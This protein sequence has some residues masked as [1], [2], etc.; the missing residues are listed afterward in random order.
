MY[1]GEASAKYY[2]G[3][4]TDG[5][6]PFFY[7]AIQFQNIC[8]LHPSKS[9]NSTLHKVWKMCWIPENFYGPESL[10]KNF[11]MMNANFSSPKRLN[12]RAASQSRAQ[13]IPTGEININVVQFWAVQEWRQ[14][15]ISRARTPFPPPP[16]HLS[17]TCPKWSHTLG[18]KPRPPILKR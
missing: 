1:V 17:T 9:I 11:E 15:P 18:F 8:E 10:K 5:H 3:K 6:C 2:Y 4:K 12:L 14:Q 7:I 13:H 16:P